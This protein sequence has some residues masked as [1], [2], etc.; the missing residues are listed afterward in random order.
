MGRR[1]VIAST[2]FIQQHLCCKTYMHI[3]TRVY[4]NKPCTLEELMPPWSNGARSTVNN[5][6]FLPFRTYLSKPFFLPGVRDALWQ[7]GCECL[8]EEVLGGSATVHH[9]QGRDRHQGAEP[10]CR[11]QLHKGRAWL[12]QEGLMWIITGTSCRQSGFFSFMMLR[13]SK[14]ISHI[15]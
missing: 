11:W 2:C 15:C 12:A 5:A 7:R 8:L 3:C 14:S 6:H 1:K 13:R 4:T 10:Q 9:G